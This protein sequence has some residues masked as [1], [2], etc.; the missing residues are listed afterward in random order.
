MKIPVDI[1]GHPLQF[2]C[3]D[4]ELSAILSATIL[5]GITYPIVDVVQDVRVVLDIGANVGASALWFSYMYPDATV[6]AFEPGATPYRLLERNTRDRPNVKRFPFGLFSHD[7]EVRLRGAALDWAEAT[8]G[9]TA[10]IQHDDASQ[11]ELVRLRSI[12]GWLA[13]ENVS[14]VDV[15]KVDTEGCEVPILASIADRLGDIPLV[16]VEYHSESDRREIDRLLEGTHAV[17]DGRVFHLHRGELTYVARTAYPSDAVYREKEIVLGLDA[18]G[19]A[20]RPVPRPEL[21]SSP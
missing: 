15:L 16:H 10:R 21:D 13:E 11:G 17:A 20:L 12:A 2:E 1:A 9:T 18:S 6:F 8:V 14:S 4:T 3:F 7:T 19:S 5:R